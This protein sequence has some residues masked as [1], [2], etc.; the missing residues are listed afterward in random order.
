[1]QHGVIRL[2]IWVSFGTAAACFTYTGWALWGWGGAATIV[3]L[4][5]LWIMAAAEAERKE[6]TELEKVTEDG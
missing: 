2:V 5:S 6:R 4:F 1:M 3:G